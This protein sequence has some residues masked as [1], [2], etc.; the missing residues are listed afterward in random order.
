MNIQS[1]RRYDSVA[2]ATESLILPDSLISV[3]NMETRR[4]RCYAAL[5]SA[6]VIAIGLGFLFANLLYLGTWSTLHGAT[7]LSVLL[8]IYLWVAAINGSYNG[9]VLRDPRVGAFTAIR[10]IAFAAAAM[11]IIAYSFKIGAAFSRLV[12]WTGTLSAVGLIIGE[13]LIL[14]RFMLRRLGGTPFSTVVLVD[15]IAWTAPSHG[16]ILDT[17]QIGFDPATDDPLEYHRLAKLVAHAD[18]VVIACRDDR[19]VAWAHVLKSM[20]VDGEI[21]TPEV[22]RIGM[23]G[24][25][26][27]HNHRTLVVSA[28]PLHLRD[29]IMKRLFD[30]IVSSIAL[31]LLSPLLVGIAI[32]IRL[33]SPGA[34]LFRQQRIGR[35]NTLFMMLKFRSMFDDQCDATASV[36]T[37]RGDSRVTRIGQFIRRNSIDELPQLINVLRGDMSMVGPRPHALSARA[38]EQLYWE[39]DARYRHRHA[40]KPGVTGLA[41]I[42]GFRGATVLTADLTN[43]LSS[44]LEYL[45]DWSMGKDMWILFRT[46][47]VIRH[48]NA[49]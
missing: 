14:G 17:A 36:L 38:A 20:A 43:R 34:V 35:D 26:H 7:I 6:D 47:F 49:F 23:I 11:L 29:R 42:R 46:I 25:S 1:K 21:L 16:M 5:V 24:V 19:V 40:V 10:A 31:L 8:P 37:T 44:D 48:D 13:R 27:Y 32:A 30:I 33:E 18:R 3:K 22:D 15:G 45:R 12:F 28:G 2:T 41:Q 39:I 9:A 4:I